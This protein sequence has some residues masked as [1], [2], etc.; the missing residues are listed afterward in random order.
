MDGLGGWVIFSHLFIGDH[1]GPEVKFNWMVD[2]R[3]ISACYLLA[4]SCS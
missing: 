1:G 4:E 3:R 2:N